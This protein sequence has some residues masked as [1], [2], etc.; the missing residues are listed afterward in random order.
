MSI[1]SLARKTI[2]RLKSSDTGASAAASFRDNPNSPWLVS[3]PRTGSHWLRMLLE[4]YT[5]QPM[6]PRSFFVHDSSKYLLV[7]THDY[8]FSASPDNVIYLYRD[9]IPTIYSQIRFHGRDVFD[10]HEVEL[11]STIYRMHLKHWLTQPREQLTTVR[12]EDM[13][14]DMVEALSPVL[15][16]L[17][18][19]IDS[20]RIVEVT[21]QV[22]RDS[23]KDAT[24]HDP[25]VVNTANDYDTQRTLFNEHMGPIVRRLVIQEGQ[26]ESYFRDHAG[27]QRL[28]A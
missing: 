18:Q 28:A 17:R 26:L 23:V 2:N 22:T 15:Y 24:K 19:P 14:R 9:P 4:R 7:H 27:P 3:F 25:R 11:W 1:R 21:E 5:Y 12:Y 20:G 10:Q 13:K 8:D 6:L 16:S